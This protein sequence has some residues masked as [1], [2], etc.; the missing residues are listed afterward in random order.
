MSAD[1]FA[2]IEWNE[3]Y[4]AHPVPEEDEDAP[5]DYPLAANLVHFAVAIASE[6]VN[7]FVDTGVK[8]S[9]HFTLGDLHSDVIWRK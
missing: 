1:G 9:V 3:N 4:R 8:E 5:C 7:K 6:V 2:E